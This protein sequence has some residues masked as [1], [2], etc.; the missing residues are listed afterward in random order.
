[1]PSK[2]KTYGVDVSFN[3]ITVIQ[4]SM[5][6]NILVTLDASSNLIETIEDNAFISNKWLT[7][8]KLTN[9]RLTK[10][11][12]NTFCGLFNL[13]DLFLNNNSIEFVQ[14]SLFRELIKLDLLNMS[15]NQIKFIEENSFSKQTFLRTLDLDLFDTFGNNAS[16]SITNSTFAG[17]T[18]LRKLV[19][20]KSVLN[21]F[22]NL[23]NVISNLNPIYD[24]QALNIS[25]FKS[26]DVIYYET[27]YTVWDCFLVLY[28]IRFKIQ[29]NLYEDEELKQFLDYCGQYSLIELSYSDIDV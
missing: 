28:S 19:L 29:V 12:N 26:R 21:S 25:Y 23:V 27:N 3:F 7:S 15:G 16:S 14:E 2:S 24:S 10:L 20:S 11:G 6:H 22:A 9:N 13:K 4:K 8:I 17:L 18:N 5:F 1:M